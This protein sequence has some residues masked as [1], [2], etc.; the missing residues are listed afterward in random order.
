MVRV[1]DR[2]LGFEGR[3]DG[4]REPALIGRWCRHDRAVTSLSVVSGAA[5]PSIRTFDSHKC[6][7]GQWL[8]DDPDQMPVTM[9]L[10]EGD[11]GFE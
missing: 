10:G 11:R 9:S 1:A 6:P 2:Q 8:R 7:N 5:L 4:L 3:F